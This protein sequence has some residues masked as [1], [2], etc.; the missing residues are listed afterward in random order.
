MNDVKPDSLRLPEVGGQD[1]G[2]GLS[3]L[4]QPPNPHHGIHNPE[5]SALKIAFATYG[6]CRSGS[7]YAAA[8]NRIRSQEQSRRPGRAP[9]SL[10]RAMRAARR[11]RGRPRGVRSSLGTETPQAPK[12]GALTGCSPTMRSSMGLSTAGLGRSAVCRVAM[13]RPSSSRSAW[14]WRRC[15]A[16]LVLFARVGEQF[17]DGIHDRVE[18]QAGG[19]DLMSDDRD[20]RGTFECSRIGMAVVASAEGRGGQLLE[21]N[22]ALCAVT[23]YARDQLLGPATESSSSRWPMCRHESKIAVVVP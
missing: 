19:V 10:V 23:G 2:A 14:K 20:F 11:S 12:S 9:C 5:T 8:H 15:A 6:S 4:P 1:A 16:W 13:L 22:D 17:L 21:V 18:A 7:T 3:L